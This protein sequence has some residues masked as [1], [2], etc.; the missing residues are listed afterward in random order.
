[1]F[2][3]VQRLYEYIESS[4]VIREEDLKREAHRLYKVNNKY[5]LIKIDNLIL[6]F[7]QNGLCI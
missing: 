2:Q 4:E 6:I 5:I 7:I 3:L 1:M